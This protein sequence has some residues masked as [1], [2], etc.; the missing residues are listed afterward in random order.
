VQVF[1]SERVFL[2][3]IGKDAVFSQRYALLGGFMLG[4]TASPSHYRF[5]TDVRMEKVDDVPCVSVGGFRVHDVARK[6]G[7]FLTDPESV[8]DR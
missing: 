6:H 8:M 7:M 4:N 1:H 3:A 5:I 2:E